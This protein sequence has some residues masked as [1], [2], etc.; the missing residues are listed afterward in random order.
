MSGANEVVFLLDMDCTLFDAAK[1][2][3]KP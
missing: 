2:G 3:N 1:G